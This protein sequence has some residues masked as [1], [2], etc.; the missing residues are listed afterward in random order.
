MGA[1]AKD[2]FKSKEVT[3]KCKGKEGVSDYV[4]F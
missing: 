4:M 1:N 2:T 3:K